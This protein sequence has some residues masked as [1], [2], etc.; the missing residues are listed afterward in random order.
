MDVVAAGV[1]L[2][3]QREAGAPR[4]ERERL[5]GRG[6]AAR[7]RVELASRSCRGTRAPPA[8]VPR[9]ER[10]QQ[11]VL[12]PPRPTDRSRPTIVSYATSSRTAA[13]YSLARSGRSVPGRVG[14]SCRWSGRRRR[15]RRA[16]PRRTACRASPGSRADCG[17][18]SLQQERRRSR[19]RASS[20]PASR[21]R[22]RAPATALRTRSR[23][24]RRAPA[25]RAA[26]GDPALSRR[27]S[28]PAVGRDGR[29]GDVGARRQHERLRRRARLGDGHERSVSH[30]EAADEHLR[31]PRDRRVVDRVDE[32]GPRIG[33]LAGGRVDRVRSRDVLVGQVR[34]EVFGLDRRAVDRDVRLGEQLGRGSCAAARRTRATPGRERGLRCAP[35]QP[36][37]AASRARC[38]A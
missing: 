10:E 29:R 28:R 18:R 33:D 7:Q 11:R 35:A 32:R 19:C 27:S 3:A 13:S 16:Q 12:V 24:A 20:R 25:G 22:R 38:R 15:S 37:P 31:Q 26:P 17:A 34:A 2:E 30:D 8:R 23:R 4:G 21:A 14:A 1:V 36:S 5:R 6:D 9:R